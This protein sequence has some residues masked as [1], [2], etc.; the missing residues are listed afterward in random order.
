MITNIENYVGSCSNKFLSNTE[1]VVNKSELMS[2]L[3]ELKQEV[4]IPFTCERSKSSVVLESREQDDMVELV[5]KKRDIT[6]EDIVKARSYLERVPCRDFVYVCGT[7]MGCSNCPHY[8]LRLVFD[9]LVTKYM[10]SN[11]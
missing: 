7:G 10:E 4:K 9:N 6:E 3:L 8:H 1:V 5:T 2:L 11:V